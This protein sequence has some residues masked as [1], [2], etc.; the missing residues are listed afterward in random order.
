MGLLYTIASFV[1]AL[2][3]LIVFHELGHYAIARWCG[4]KVLRF[5][6]GFGKPLLVKRLGADQTEWALA[7]FPLGGYVKMLDEREGEVDKEEAHRA[8][9]RQTVGK[10]FAIVAAG[11]IANFLL[12]ILLY[13]GLFVHGLP[14]IKPEL[15]PIPADTPAAAAGFR[16]GELI[17]QVD[18]DP[19]VTWN[20][21]RWMLLKR[22]VNRDAVRLEVEDASGGRAWRRLDLSQMDSEELDGDFVRRLGL[23]PFQPAVKPVVGKVLDD[24]PGAKAGLREGDEIVAAGNR[25]VS[26]WEELVAAVRGA[27]GR[28]LLLE[29]RR[30][31]RML[32]LTVTPDATGEGPEKVGRIGVAPQLDR[33]ALERLVTHVRYGPWEALSQ[34]LRKTWETSA[35]TFQVL[36]KMITGE[37]SWKNVSGPITIADYAGQSAQLG[38]VYYVIFL[39]SI[40]ISL[41]VLNLLPIPLLDG[42]HLMYYMIELAKGSPLSEKAMEIG[43]Q[44]GIALLLTLM[45]FAIYND[46]NRLISG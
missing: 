30:E 26:Q 35:F 37:V 24:G 16:Q 4:V 36:G 45:A 13:W 25:P 5:S 29:V 15:G 28:E 44:V 6:V 19:V 3:I 46:L 33:G 38:W 12:A 2:G 14:G 23:V 20:D 9:N 40:S 39:A 8:F 10:R 22:A 7:A 18:D 34:A 41:G 21:L 1:L 31:G 43:Q 27:P 11:P 32:V 17:R 42:G